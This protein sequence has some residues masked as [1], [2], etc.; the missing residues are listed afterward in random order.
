MHANGAVHTVIDDDKNHADVVLHRGGEFLSGHQKIA[1]AAKSYDGAM[2]VDELRRNARWRAITHRAIG[3]C[4]LRTRLAQ[5]IKA[6][7]PLAKI[8]GTVGQNRIGR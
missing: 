2:G 8:S 3:R 5:R 1:V 4:Q 6:M 7:Q